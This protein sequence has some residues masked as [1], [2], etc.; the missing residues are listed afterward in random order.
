MRGH[1][2]R[3]CFNPLPNLLELVVAEVDV[4]GDH[5]GVAFERFG[6]CADASGDAAR[7]QEAFPARR[8]V[9]EYDD[10]RQ[11]RVPLAVRSGSSA[12]ARHGHDDHDG[13][14]QQAP[15]QTLSALTKV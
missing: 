7:P 1:D 15:G 11:V 8:G 10:E 14:R 6:E 2:C 12:P 9:R 4:H 5:G 3:A 13:E